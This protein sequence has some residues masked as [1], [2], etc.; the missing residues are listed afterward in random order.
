MAEGT[1]WSSW[2]ENKRFFSGQI[3]TAVLVVNGAVSYFCAVALAGT[4]PKD[5]ISPV[6]RF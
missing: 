2:G 6:L 5:A 4:M 3:L 1:R